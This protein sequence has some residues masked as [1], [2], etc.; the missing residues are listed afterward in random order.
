MRKIF[1]I[2]S[3]RKTAKEFFETLK[4]NGVTKIIDVRLNN[5]LQ[6]LGF[7]KYPDIEYFTEEILKGEY[8]Y[9]KKFA[10]S[11]KIFVRYKKNQIDWEGYEKEFAELMAYREIDV[12]IADKY[13]DKENYCLLCSEPSPENCHRRLVAEKIRDVLG[14][15]EIIH[16]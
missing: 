6:I 4:E 15:V 7:S 9:D 5:N 2:G 12:Y 1:T 11:E 13:G 8:F 16:L 10:P 3:S 14:D